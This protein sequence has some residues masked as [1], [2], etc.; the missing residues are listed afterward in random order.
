MNRSRLYQSD[1]SLHTGYW[2]KLIEACAETETVICVHTGSAGSLPDTAPGAPRDVVSTLF[3]AGF[4]LMEGVA[5][6][7]EVLSTY[8]VAVPPGTREQRAGH[9]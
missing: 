5:V 3:G 4:S 7:R 2:D 8:D 6:L 9:R 1:I